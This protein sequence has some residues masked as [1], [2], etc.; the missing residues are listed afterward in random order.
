MK[1]TYRDLIGSEITPYI[2][3]LAELRIE[4]FREWPYLYEGT[5]DYERKYLA[6]LAESP[7]G[8]V[9]LAFDGEIVVGASTALPLTDAEDAFQKPFRE[10]GLDPEDYFYFGESVLLPAYRGQGAGVKFFEEREAQAHFLAFP[11]SC[12]CAVLRP[13]DSPAKPAD[14]RS[15]DGL[16]T[17]RGFERRPELRATFSWPDLGETEESEK[18]LEFWVRR[19]DADF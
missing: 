14:Y 3:R 7:H 12:F 19:E 9:V 10:A 6:R 15:L 16:W 17:R 1:L 5:M 13:D 4:V 2:D 8:Y 11:F 18:V